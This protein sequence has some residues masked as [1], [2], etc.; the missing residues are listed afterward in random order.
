MM[1]GVSSGR[2]RRAGLGLVLLAATFVPTAIAVNAGSDI[3]GSDTAAS[4]TAD[5]SK[6]SIDRP[7]GTI[8]YLPGS[9]GTEEP[10][11]TV[12]AIN[13][14]GKF[15]GQIVVP[16]AIGMADI[17]KSDNALLVTEDSRYFAIDSA[18]DAAVKLDFPEYSDKPIELNN[19]D[20]RSSE[21]WRIY[22][23][24]DR[25]TSYLIDLD[26]GEVEDLE[27]WLPGGMMNSV[28]TAI[29]ADGEYLAIQP[30]V[31][32]YGLQIG[33]SIDQSKVKDF[34]PGSAV[35]L[36]FSPDSKWVAFE[37]ETSKGKGELIVSPVDDSGA[38]LVVSTD[39][40]SYPVMVSDPDRVIFAESRAEK[41]IDVKVFEPATGSSRTLFRTGGDVPLLTANANGKFAVMSVIYIH[42]VQEPY[43]VTFD[44]NSGSHMALE[45]KGWYFPL[46]PDGDL[47]RTRARWIPLVTI[48]S[49]SGPSPTLAQ[50]VLDFGTGK[51]S[52][53]KLDTD[54]WQ[55][56]SLAV[57]I[58]GHYWVYE[59]TDRGTPN[60]V[61]L[62]DLVTSTTRT[63]FAG[64]PSGVDFS[65]DDCW[66]VFGGFQ[67]QS[68]DQ[69]SSIYITPAAGGP[70]T[71]IA[72][73]TQPVWLES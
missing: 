69:G 70:I 51:V 9:G 25:N 66:I 3:A 32:D 19:V 13:P 59:V 34:G 7:N 67:D 8:L 46:S 55:S 56:G 14:S 5:V 40:I 29:S 17:G 64:E 36:S 65:P 27:L 39:L 71:K 72:E 6:C 47:R 68:G 11:D 63:L 28:G 20:P 10:S 62:L 15:L 53:L 2:L 73:G 43:T 30:F 21:R 45:T 33:P 22:N 4:P 18:L 41:Q 52:T 16:G 60:R 44:L 37:R 54:F 57:S 12:E 61:A 31:T 38:Q 24:Y 26:T 1:L 23:A 50:Y 48:D 49:T 42:G 35:D 58:D